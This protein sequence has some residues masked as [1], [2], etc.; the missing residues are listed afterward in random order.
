VRSEDEMATDAV[1][2][3]RLDVKSER[4]LDPSSGEWARCE[5]HRIDLVPA[6][7]A[8]VYPVSPYLA[9]SQG[10]GRIDRLDARV[11]HNEETFSVR[12]SWSDPNRDDRITDLDGF[13]DACAISFPLAEWANPLTMGDPERPVNAWLWRADQEEPF[14][15]IARGYSTSERRPAQESGLVAHAL[16]ED[17]EWRLVFQ[18]PLLVPKPD[19]VRF[20]PKEWS[21]IAFAVWEGS[22]RERSGQKAV[23][24]GYRSLDLNR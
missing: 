3:Q 8:M 22:N 20:E 16:Y 11:A 18:R 17:G 6:P 21:G 12:V 24:G 2:A 15:V 14:D 7:V 13:V 10:H 4:L 9:T 5:R 19:Y 23:S 1:R